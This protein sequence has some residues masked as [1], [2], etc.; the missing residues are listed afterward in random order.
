[1]E[2]RLAAAAD[3]GGA[4]YC[5]CRGPNDGGLMIGCDGGCDEWFHGACVGIDVRSL[6]AGRLAGWTA[7]GMPSGRAGFS[8]IYASGCARASCL[9]SEATAAGKSFVCPSCVR[10]LGN[11]NASSGAGRKRGGG[12]GRPKGKGRL[13]RGGRGLRGGRSRRDCGSGSASD[14]GS[15]D[16]SGGGAGGGGDEGI[17]TTASAAEE[18]EAEAGLPA[19]E[20]APDSLT[21]GWSADLACDWIPISESEGMVVL[22]GRSHTAA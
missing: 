16:V 1:M 18:R 2:S 4:R 13:G 19:P 11:G 17:N 14:S 20:P 10:K 21:A 8:H 22:G 6:P 5:V 15:E 12:S 7:V 9:Q 3:D